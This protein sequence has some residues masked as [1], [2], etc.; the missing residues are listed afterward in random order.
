MFLGEFLNRNF[1]NMDDRLYHDKQSVTVSIEEKDGKM[2]LKND[3]G[4]EW[5][6][7]SNVPQRSAI[8]CLVFSTILHKKDYVE[9]F[10]G[11]YRITVEVQELIE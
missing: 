6:F 1:E 4:N 10:A 8:A 11:N 2:I 3:L 9:T 5:I 7:P